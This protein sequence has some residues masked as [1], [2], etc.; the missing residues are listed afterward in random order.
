MVIE[1]YGDG[2]KAYMSPAYHAMYDSNWTLFQ[3]MHYP[4][5]DHLVMSDPMPILANGLKVF[6]RSGGDLIEDTIHWTHIVMLLS[7]L[8]SAL[9]LY[10]ILE[11]LRLPVWL[12]VV[13]ALALSFMAPMVARMGFH[14]GLAQP[15]ALP[16]VFYLLMRFQE[17]PR[18][19][20]SALLSFVILFFSLFHF[21]YFGLFALGISL[22]YFVDFLIVGQGRH[23]LRILPHYALQVLF[24]FALLNLWL[25][26]GPDVSDRASQPWGFLFY[27]AR[28]EGLFSSADQRHWQWV[29]RWVSRLPELDIEAQ[30]YIGLFAGLG[31][32]LLLA[33]QL[34]AGFRRPLLPD[35]VPHRAFLVRLFPASLLLL[36]FA[37]GLPFA[38]PGFEQLLRFTG[39][40]QQ[41]RALGRFSWM[42][43]FAANIFVL[44]WA[45]YLLRRTKWALGLIAALLCVESYQYITARDLALDPV[46]GLQAT[47]S[48]AQKALI[49]PS[50]YQAITTVP[51]FHLGSESFWWE[52][53]G[54]QQEA[55]VLALR[56]GL[57]MCNAMLSRTSRSQTIKQ[58]QLMSEPYRL[59]VLLE[60]LPDQRPLLLLYD[61]RAAAGQSPK[62]DHFR[63]AMDTMGIELLYTTNDFNLYELPLDFFEKNLKKREQEMTTLSDTLAEPDPSR[64]VRRSFDE[65]KSGKTY[66]GAGAF[67]SS[68]HKAG[69]LYDGPLPPAGLEG[70]YTLSFWAFVDE[71]L[72]SRSEFHVRVYRPQTGETTFETREG[73]HRWA[74]VFDPKGWALVEYNLQAAAGT[75]LHVSVQNKMLGK[76]PLYFDEWLLRPADYAVKSSG[77][78]FFSYNNRFYKK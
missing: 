39:P 31:L 59:P 7:I 14:F 75:H 42:F 63:N 67:Q 52:P 74:T 48:L 43:Y 8:F 13:A 50:D 33:I 62:W 40:L 78:H 1:P 60:D 20:Y 69:V 29:D 37:L 76:A 11:R 15:A 4:Y 24:P 38:L 46:P 5:G 36:L 2:L 26:S 34:R 47:E 51:F 53:T 65:L 22:Y 18:W 27:R 41:F 57:P 35:A 21:H 19:A 64:F 16:M 56:T 3:G 49:D 66:Q 9:F 71:D 25:G 61:K 17:S 58:L 45:G 12:A 30:N 28:L 73:I 68:A 54:L 44:A 23:L 55:M 70:R 6:H 77:A 32:F 72:R 10:L